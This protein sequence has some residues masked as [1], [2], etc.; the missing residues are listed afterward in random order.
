MVNYRK[1]F[2]QSRNET[3]W[4]V[5]EIYKRFEKIDVNH[6]VEVLLLEFQS[7]SMGSNDMASDIA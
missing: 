3:I 4:E 2:L 1:W 5:I 6:V 7:I